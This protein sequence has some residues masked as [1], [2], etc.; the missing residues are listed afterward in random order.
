DGVTQPVADG[1]ES[2][3][4]IGY[5]VQ[6]VQLPDEPFESVIAVIQ[7][8]EACSTFWP[9]IRDGRLQELSDEGMK[10]SFAAGVSVRAID[11]ILATRMRTQIKHVLKDVFNEIDVIAAPSLPV[12]ANALDLDIDRAFGGISDPL[13]ALGN[14]LGLP[15]V[16]VPCGFSNGLPVGMV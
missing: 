13:G 4:K 16:S 3:K 12:V 5:T 7:R 8:S 6:P 2:L 11:Y 15:C 10:T 14:L 1:I 9:L